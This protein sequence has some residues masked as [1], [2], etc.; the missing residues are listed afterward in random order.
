MKIKLLL[1]AIAFSTAALFVP[2]ISAKKEGKEARL[3]REA[4]IT[5]T[6]ARQKALARAPGTVEF[7][8]LER[9]KG[10]KV[11]FEFEIHTVQKRESEVHVD[12]VTGEVFSVSEE[13]G[14]VSAKKNAM[15]TGTKIS[16]D[17]AEKA[18]LGRVIGAVVFS[19]V[20]RTRGKIL[21]EFK[22]IT[23]DGKEAEVHVNADSGLVEGVEQD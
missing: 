5:M 10:G 21:Y 15:L 3:V 2:V 19:N 14:Q 22:I 23:S 13:S 17:D 18:A 1:I 4:K 9:G 16:L 7:A 20:E 6:E 8:R 11:L 12:A